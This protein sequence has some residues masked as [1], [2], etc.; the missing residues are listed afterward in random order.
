MPRVPSAAASHIG[1]K[2]RGARLAATLTQ[3]QVA[4]HSG[5]DSSNIRAYETGRAMPSVPTLVRIADALGIAPGSLLEGL[6][7]GMLPIA[8]IDGRRRAS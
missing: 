6:T 7:V 5:I 1:E 4:A 8:D 2:I 3:D